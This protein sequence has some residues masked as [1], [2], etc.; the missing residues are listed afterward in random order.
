MTVQSNA[1]AESFFSSFKRELIHRFRFATRAQATAAIE[2]W[3]RRYNTVRLHSSLGY[4]PPLE[5]ELNY[6]LEQLQA[7]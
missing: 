7:A 1:M 3:I 6:R 4:V 2:A 5:W